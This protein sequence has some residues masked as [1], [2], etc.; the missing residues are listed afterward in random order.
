MSVQ[1]ETSNEDIRV[2]IHAKVNN[3]YF[4]QLLVYA[5]HFK[6]QMVQLISLSSS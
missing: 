3:R 2:S 6:R 1:V 4:V 5:T